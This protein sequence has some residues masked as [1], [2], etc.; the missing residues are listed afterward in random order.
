LKD[1]RALIAIGSLIILLLVVLIVVLMV[2][3]NRPQKVSIELSPPEQFTE[4]Y[5]TG[6][7]EAKAEGDL[8]VLKLAIEAYNANHKTLPAT[9]D[10]LTKEKVAIISVLPN[11]PFGNK[12]GYATNGKYYA[13]WSI[14]SKGQG[15]PCRISPNGDVSV[16]GDNQIGTTNGTPPNSN[17]R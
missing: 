10:L 8:R 9:L 7:K 3:M 2:N 15:K 16:G 11:D 17:W 13:I 6:A 14:G 5:Q 12:Y 4:A 1:N